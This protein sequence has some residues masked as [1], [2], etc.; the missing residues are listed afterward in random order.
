MNTISIEEAQ[1]KLAELIDHLA[2]G[3]SLVITR[4]QKPVARLTVEEAA[5][6]RPRQPGSAKGL[7]AIIK[8]DEEHL[9]DFQDYMERGLCS[10]LI[11]C[12]GFCS[13]TLV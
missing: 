8:E 11:R 5:S 13:T 3:E 4:N 6:R 7:L 2:A 9:A 10:I 12:S 1:A